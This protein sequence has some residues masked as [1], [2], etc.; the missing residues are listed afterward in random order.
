[1]R[2]DKFRL[3]CLAGRGQ[4]LIIG[5]E[6]FLLGIGIAKMREVH[7]RRRDVAAELAPAGRADTGNTGRLRIGRAVDTRHDRAGRETEGGRILLDVLY[8]ARNIGTDEFHVQCRKI[9]EQLAGPEQGKVARSLRAVDDDVLRAV[10][11][12]RLD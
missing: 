9:G 6:A 5:P 4:M 2:D 3:K 1:L 8:E 10:E 11:R 12:Q 7:L